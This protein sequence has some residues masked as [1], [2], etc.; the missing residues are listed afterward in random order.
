MKRKL[1]DHIEFNFL[2]PETLIVHGY[3]QSEDEVFHATA[4][5][6][7]PSG[8]IEAL[9]QGA[10]NRD[11][12]PMDLSDFYSQCSSET[13]DEIM[14]EQG[15][16]MESMMAMWEDGTEEWHPNSLQRLMGVLTDVK[17]ARFQQDKRWPSGPFLPPLEWSAILSKKLGQASQHALHLKQNGN[18]PGD[19]R[20]F[21]RQLLNIA[22][23][24][25][26]AIE[27]LDYDLVEPGK[28]NP[29]LG[30][31]APLETSSA[32]ES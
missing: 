25:C 27:Q 26:A 1:P 7:L 3:Y 32:A 20:K 23:T 14:H 24:A 15:D 12:T 28:E 29:V 21:R 4:T 2:N 18:L 17:Q 30:L 11:A 22:A 8:I 13:M 9:D 10:A 6:T 16:S 19:V 5:V 31:P